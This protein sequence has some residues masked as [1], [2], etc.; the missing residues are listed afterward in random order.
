MAAQ[1]SIFEQLVTTYFTTTPS[2][3]AKE[4]AIFLANAYISAT[5]TAQTPFGNTT[6][7][8]RLDILIEA[9]ESTFS[10]NEKSA[11]PTT[12]DTYSKLAQGII[13]YWSPGGVILNPLPPASPTIAPVVA[14]FFIPTIQFN[15]ILNQA[16]NNISGQ[17]PLS[18]NEIRNALIQDVIVGDPFVALPSPIVLFP[19][20]L[21]PLQAELYLAFTPGN[22]AQQ[23][24]QLLA[25]AF[26]NHL[27]TLFGIYIGFMPPG[28]PLPIN[29]IPWS[30]IN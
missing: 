8:P 30:G 24:A 27:S 4:S 17:L 22:T 1:W 12:P 25:Q 18:S 20:A 26:R 3:S 19:G 15:E 11:S 6:L 13:K 14:G 9:F 28:S 10:S 7:I 2:R 23:S 21:Q 5:A 29:I 16:V